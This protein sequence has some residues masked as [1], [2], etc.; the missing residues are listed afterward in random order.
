MGNKQILEF[1]GGDG[2]SNFFSMFPMDGGV[3]PKVHFKSDGNSYVM[4][5][6]AIGTDDP[7]GYKF[8]VNGDAIFTKVKVKA[9]NTWPDYVFEPNF[10]LRSLAELEFFIKQNKH[11]P[12][13]PSA[14]EVEQNGLDLGNSQAV[15]LKKIEE[16]TLYMIEMNKKIGKIS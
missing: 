3:N 6:L 8:A 16:L 13:V 2:N 9:F 7:K 1:G 15:L 5:S 11:L 14:A 10:K 12:E 4:G